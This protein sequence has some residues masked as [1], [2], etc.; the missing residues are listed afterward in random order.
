M[1]CKGRLKLGCSGKCRKRQGNRSWPR[2]WREKTRSYYQVHL[3]TM[4]SGSCFEPDAEV[5]TDINIFESLILLLS[6]PTFLCR[7]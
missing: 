6:H 7:T 5:T 2:L 3:G 1:I 4:L